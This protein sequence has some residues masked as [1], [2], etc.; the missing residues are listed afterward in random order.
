MRSYLL[1]VRCDVAGDGQ[2]ESARPRARAYEYPVIGSIQHTLSRGCVELLPL[3]PPFELGIDRWGGSSPNFR[4]NPTSVHSP[5]STVSNV[6]GQHPLLPLVPILITPV[7]VICQSP[8]VLALIARL[9]AGCVD[10]WGQWVG[11][12]APR[13]AA[14]ACWPS[15]YFTGRRCYGY[16]ATWWRV[17][18]S[19]CR[20]AAMRRVLR[21]FC[22]GAAIQRV[23]R[24]VAASCFTRLAVLAAENP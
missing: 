14:R 1:V 5:R 15:K 20:G 17:S 10:R 22:R 19:F 6:L 11:A 18:W 13:C 7:L 9:C 8:F 12:G 21:P 23:A 24:L 3:R 16:G 4:M 2:T